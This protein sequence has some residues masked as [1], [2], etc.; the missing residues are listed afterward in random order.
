MTNAQL[1]GLG[2]RLFSVWLAVYCLRTLPAMFYGNRWDVYDERMLAIAAVVTAILLAACLFL[3]FFPLTV[4]SKLIPK[5]SLAV[6][7]VPPG[8]HLQAAGFCLLGL[9]VLSSA[10]PR[11]VNF[12]ILYYYSRQ[13]PTPGLFERTY[14]TAAEAV[15]EI[16]IGVWLLFGARGLL[17]ILRSA[18]TAG[19]RD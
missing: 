9:W 3:W 16:A 11:T 4:A 14:A 15:A 6:P 8:E 13:E 17:E 7:V 2:V 19:L 18:R 5:T 1:V 10:I 12:V